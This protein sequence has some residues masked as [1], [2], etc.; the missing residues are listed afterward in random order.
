MDDVIEARLGM[1]LD[2][3]IKE[4][5]KIVVKKPKKKKPVPAKGGNNAAN[6]KA[7]TSIMMYSCEFMP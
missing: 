4:Q 3:L 5:K 2:D 7:C 6:S 1:S